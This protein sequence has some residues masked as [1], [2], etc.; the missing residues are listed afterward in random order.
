MK[1]NDI[2]VNTVINK[3]DNVPDGFSEEAGGIYSEIIR[4][5]GAGN[6]DKNFSQKN[7]LPTRLRNLVTLGSILAGQLSQDVSSCVEDC[8][9]AGATKEQIMEVLRLV[10][11]MAEIPVQKYTEIVQEAIQ[12]F[13][14]L[15]WRQ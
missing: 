13:E 3:Y 14:D 15:Q 2:M 4:M 5:L 9:K 11:V 12:T 10:I 8:L 7:V 1:L 6:N